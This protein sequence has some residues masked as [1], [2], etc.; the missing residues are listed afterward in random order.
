MLSPM[1]IVLYVGV[2]SSLGA[3]GYDQLQ[4]PAV[5]SSD[6][7]A[8]QFARG[9]GMQREYTMNLWQK[10]SKNCMEINQLVAKIR[11]EEYSVTVKPGVVPDWMV[12]CTNY[13]RNAARPLAIDELYAGCKS[14]CLGDGSDVGAV[15][16]KEFCKGVTPSSTFCPGWD[17]EDCRAGFVAAVSAD[18]AC[19]AK[20]KAMG[21]YD[22]DLMVQDRCLDTG[23]Y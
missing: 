5:C 23:S 12:I 10:S 21:E 19:A 11:A 18:G 16:A 13:G 6:A 9:V 22:F 20:A 14:V 8:R 15:L 2:L 1:S 4:P 17:L 7:N 3:G